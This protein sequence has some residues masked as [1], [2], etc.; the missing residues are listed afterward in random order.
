MVERRMLMSHSKIMLPT[1][2]GMIC[3]R[4]AKPEDLELGAAGGADRLDRLRI[5][6]LDASAIVLEMKPI[7]R[8][9]IASTPA[10]A[11]RPTAET[12]IRAQTISCTERDIVIRK[13]PIAYELLPKGG[14]LDAPPGRDR[15][16]H[17]QAPEDG[18]ERRHHHR[19]ERA[20]PRASGH[21]AVV[22]SSS[23]A[24]ECCRAANRRRG[25]SSRCR[26]RR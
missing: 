20:A 10:S 22:D 24:R 15:D 16:R 19:L 1:N 6:V 11:P 2:T 23:T 14:M 21:D 12:K 7:E 26:G 25:A 9:A 17:H 8:T 13:R 4:I 5:D 3:G 18:G